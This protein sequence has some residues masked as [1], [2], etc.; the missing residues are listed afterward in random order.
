MSFLDE[1]H[2]L[3]MIVHIMT[4]F[5]LVFVLPTV[6]IGC[7]RLISPLSALIII[8]LWE[9]TE[10]ILLLIY[11]GTYGPWFSDAIAESSFD[12]WVLDIG[13]GIMGI[14]LAMSF[15]YLKNFQSKTIK[16]TFL[17]AFLLDSKENLKTKIFF[18]LI[19]IA[20][21]AAAVAANV[22]WEC[23]TWIPSL[24]VNGYNA[25]PWGTPLMVIIYVLYTYWMNLPVYTYLLIIILFIPSF[26]SAEIMPVPASFIQL[27]IVFVLGVVL[28]GYCIFDRYYRRISEKSYNPV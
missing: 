17:E 21:G 18:F 12:V 6:K 26:I 2:G 15:Q 7:F 14:L 24:C 28:F 5:F 4:P 16:G 25:F 19:F 8:L 10:W 1:P 9:F 3:W 20:P 23:N 27:I 13:G 22:G 11:D